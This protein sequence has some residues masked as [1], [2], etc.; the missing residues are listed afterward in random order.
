MVDD[1]LR[2]AL[3]EGHIEGVEHELRAQVRGHGPTDHA[4]TEGVEH[5]GEIEEPG[6]SGNVGS[7]RAKKDSLDR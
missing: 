5:D 3:S 2:T 1:V 6:P 7:P 4:S